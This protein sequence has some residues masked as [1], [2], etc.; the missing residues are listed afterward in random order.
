MYAVGSSISGSEQDPSRTPDIVTSPWE[1]QSF[2]LPGLTDDGEGVRAVWVTDD[3]L[4]RSG[5]DEQRRVDVSVAIVVTDR[6]VLFALREDTDDGPSGVH[7]LAYADLAAVDR[8]TAALSLTTTAGVTWETPLPRE[9]PP[10]FG[11]VLNHLQWVG[12]LR[13]RAIGCRNDVEL[14][15]G[16]IRD[17]AHA[18]DWNRAR[19]SYEDAR[20]VLDDLICD[21]QLVEPVDAAHLVPALTEMERQLERAH[22]H[23]RIERAK[24]DLTLGRHLIENGEYSKAREHLRDAQQYY[25]TARQQRDAVERPDSFQFGPQ[26]ELQDD[27]ENLGWE[28]ETVAAEPIR[29]AHEAKIQAQFADEADEALA[30]WESAFERYGDVL[31]LE[32]DDAG[33]NFAGDPD[34]VRTQQVDA[35]DQVVELRDE[36]ASQEWDTGA[37]CQQAGDNEAALRHCTSAIDHLERARVVAQGASSADP[38]AIATR[39]DRMR[40]VVDELRETISEGEPEATA[41]VRGA[42]EGE[43]VAETHPDRADEPGAGVDGPATSEESREPAEATSG[44]V[45]SATGDD[46]G[47]GDQTPSVEELTNIDTHQEIT[48][49]FEDGSPLAASEEPGSAEG[50]GDAATVRGDRTTVQEKA[51]FDDADEDET[52]SNAGG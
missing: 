13:A 31:T 1:D 29:Q 9:I 22:V 2:D 16:Q 34:E 36:L 23:L 33:R 30:H 24:S 28:I 4:V 50:T 35:A 6:R 45:S 39:L 15:A 41:S 20:Q 52:G 14:A 18:L 44:T 43:S 37:R 19:S 40:A 48:L 10:D 25:D 38:A 47:S 46:G 17:H 3:G 5:R 8:T 49:T 12:R 26:R 32:W 51:E 7:S 11:L 42:Y 27:L 21:V